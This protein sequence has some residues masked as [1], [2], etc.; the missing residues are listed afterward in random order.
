MKQQAKKRCAETRFSNSGVSGFSYQIHMES[1][2]IK[3]DKTRA[4]RAT[5][6]LTNSFRLIR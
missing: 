5:K 2:E 6:Q 1:E 4:K 3:I